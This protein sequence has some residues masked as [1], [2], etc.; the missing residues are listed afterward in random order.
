[1]I[2]P[3]AIFQSLTFTILHFSGADTLNQ[4]IQIVAAQRSYVNENGVLQE[5]FHVLALGQ[6]YGVINPQTPGRFVEACTMVSDKT[7]LYDVYAIESK[8]N[9]F[10]GRF[11]SLWTHQ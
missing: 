5:P 3:A 6:M 7:G 9:V 1:M 4:A 8:F 10:D 11:D 2:G